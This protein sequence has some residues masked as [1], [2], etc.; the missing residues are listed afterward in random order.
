MQ[1]HEILAEFGYR[2]VR[3]NMIMLVSGFAGAVLFAYGAFIIDRPTGVAGI[4]VGALVGKILFGV[5]ACSA[6]ARGIIGL[7]YL[8]FPGGRRIALTATSILAPRRARWG[9]SQKEIEIPFEAIRSVE[10][11]DY[12]N[13]TKFLSIEH[14]GGVYPLFEFRLRQPKQFYRLYELIQKAVW[15]TQLEEGAQGRRE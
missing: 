7:M 2:P 4:Q 9:F 6:A 15:M 13:N 3:A 11:R 8:V 5:A 14:E 1:E 12:V 10:L